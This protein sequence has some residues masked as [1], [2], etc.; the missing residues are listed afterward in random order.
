[1]G[2][3]RD[4]ERIPES[5]ALVHAHVVLHHITCG[6]SRSRHD[7]MPC[8]SYGDCVPRRPATRAKVVRG[9]RRHLRF[10]EQFGR[11]QDPQL[12]A[13]VPP[14]VAAAV[15]DQHQ[16]AKRVYAEM[17]QHEI[18]WDD[19]AAA[20]GLSE[21]QA[22]RLLRGESEMGLDRM[23]QLAT[24]VDYRLRVIYQPTRPS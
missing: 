3:A 21:E 1:M 8:G 17:T 10:P 16:L 20:I 7:H 14:H 18:G 23:H 12:M 19:L 11:V 24:A 15:L 5:G 22:R 9:P 4:S 13:G 6:T 2:M